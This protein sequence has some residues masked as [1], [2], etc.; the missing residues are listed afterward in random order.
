MREGFRFFKQK[1]G[2][3]LAPTISIL[4]RESVG[5]IFFSRPGGISF[6]VMAKEVN[7]NCREASGGRSFRFQMT[8]GGVLLSE[9]CRVMPSV[10]LPFKM[11]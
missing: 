11:K 1:K 4:L 10:H 3:W 2:G 6:R 9:G 8:L 7:S 5:G